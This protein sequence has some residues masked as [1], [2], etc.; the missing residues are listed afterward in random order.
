MKNKTLGIIIVLLGVI[1]IFA[2]Q[3]FAWIISAIM[4]G[5]GSGLFFWKE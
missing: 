5:I 1:A 3:D 4:I 2:K